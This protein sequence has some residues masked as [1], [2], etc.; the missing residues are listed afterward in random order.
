MDATRSF[1]ALGVLQTP[2]STRLLPSAC[3]PD[4][5]LIVL[6]SRLGGRDRLGLWNYSHG[7]KIWEVDGGVG[8]ENTVIDIVDIAWSPD[9]QSIVAVHNPP[10]VTLHS[11]QD[12]TIQFTLSLHQVLNSQP[13]KMI[14]VWWFCDIRLAKT[15][16]IPDILRRNDIIAGTSHAILRTLPLLDALQDDSQRLTATDL[17]AFQGTQTRSSSKEASPSVI[18]EWP[19]LPSDPLSASIKAPLSRKSIDPLEGSKSETDELNLN[20]LL[21]LADSCGSMHYYLDGTFPLGSIT[22][23]SNF[24]VNSLMKDQTRPTFIAYSAARVQETIATSLHP[25]I[26]DVPL[27]GKRH[28][29]DMAKLSSTARELMW[30]CMNAINEMHTTWFG[31]ETFS[32]ARHLGP[33]WIQALEAKQK[34]QFGQAEPNAILDLTTLLVT[35]RATDSLLDFLGSGEQMSERGILKWESTM[36]EALVKLRDYSEKRITP[37]CQRLHLVLEET[38]GWAQLSAFTPFE[39]SLKEIHTCLEIT[40]QMI[41]L[42]AWLAATARQELF[43]F[44]AFL[45]WLRFETSVANPSSDNPPQPRH[46]IL[47]VN[48]YLVSGLATSTIDRWF[49]GPAP[50]FSL[51]DISRESDKSIVDVIDQARTVA[52]GNHA[53]SGFQSVFPQDDAKFTNRNLNTLVNEL[54]SRCKCIFDRAASAATRSAAVHATS[55]ADLTSRTRLTDYLTPPP[56][57]ERTINVNEGDLCQFL[58]L[59]VQTEQ[60][61]CLCLSRLY[62]R[63][64]ALESPSE[65]G[66]ALFEPFILMGDEETSMGLDLLEADFL[67]DDYVV[68][69]YRNRGEN[70]STHIAMFNYSGLRYQLVQT[71]QHVNLVV[72]EELMLETVEQWKQGHLSKTRK[73]IERSRALK[74]GKTGHVSLALNGRLGRRVACVL[75]SKGTL[76]S[77]D[78]EGDEDEETE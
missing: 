5:D 21:V 51:I 11:L 23:G 24:F 76:E 49:T 22:L 9:G 26:V 13:R 42:S 57:R 65:I 25:I 2:P 52:R 41:L 17:F 68:I 71:M 36:T 48:N 62:Y 16:S 64:E 73:Q 59:S 69:V 74:G 33:K 27:L 30:Y 35:G 50:Q 34:D 78:M 58:M 61:N 53:S 47:E 54:A 46:D 44:R 40:M 75:D 31:S 66:I 7:S 14:G 77:F 6:I 56:M 12:G 60:T 8:D 18:H 32:G 4:K 67:D 29:R 38:Q 20:S 19:T 1:S 72:R 15:R 10:L 3:C 45:H 70:K 39:L 55:A 63:K 28:I 43:R 37:A